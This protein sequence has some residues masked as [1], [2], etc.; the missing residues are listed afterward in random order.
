MKLNPRTSCPG[1]TLVEILI[2][3]TIIGILV[4]LA[5]PGFLNARKTAQE[6]T[7]LNNLRQIATAGQQYILQYGVK[8]VS[9]KSLIPTYFAPIEPVAG[10]NYSTLTV[11]AGK[12]DPSKILSVQSP[13]LDDPVTYAY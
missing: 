2:V 6:K 1:F 4:A 13:A 10:E 11:K 7:I 3:V 5:V 8:S 9:Y 12:E